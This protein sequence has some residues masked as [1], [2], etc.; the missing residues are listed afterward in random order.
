MFIKIKKDK[1]MYKKYSILQNQS[2]YDTKRK[3]K[4]K[5]KKTIFSFLK[6]QDRP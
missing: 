4:K 5:K 1:T 6:Y 3:G 2:Y